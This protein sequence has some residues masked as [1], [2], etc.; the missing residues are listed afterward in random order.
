MNIGGDILEV[1]WSHPELGSGVFHPKKSEE[2]Y[3]RYPRKLKKKLKKL[4]K[5]PLFK[6][7]LTPYWREPLIAEFSV[8][9][10][11]TFRKGFSMGKSTSPFL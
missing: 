9:D 6:T 1:T 4:G 10:V 7:S 3:K 5:W 2:F 11:I 8:G